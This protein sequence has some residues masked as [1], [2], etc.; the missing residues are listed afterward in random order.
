ME[1]LMSFDTGLMFWTWVTFL[2]VLLILGTKAWKPMITML[3]K[4]EAFIKDSLAQANEARLEAEKVAKEYDEMVAKARKEAQEI[5]MAGK[6]TAEK[7][8]G[9]ILEDAKAKAESLMKQAERQ[10]EAERDKAIAE[11]RNQIVDL[12]LLAA[13]KVVGKEVSKADNERLINETLR[14][15]GQN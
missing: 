2:V 10:I 15:F 13:A 8:K 5:V 3:E 11:I 12:S 4:R 6:S 14:E 9:D 7:M 1:N